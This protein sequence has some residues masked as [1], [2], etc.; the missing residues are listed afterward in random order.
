MTIANIK[1]QNKNE[2]TVEE[3]SGNQEKVVKED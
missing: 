3:W 1:E 2:K